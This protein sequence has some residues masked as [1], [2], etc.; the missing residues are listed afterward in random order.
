MS[1]CQKWT[2]L[3]INPKPH[4]HP[5]AIKDNDLFEEREYVSNLGCYNW[6]M[7]LG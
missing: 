6:S 1:I 7:E 4:I 5:L 3:K 2:T